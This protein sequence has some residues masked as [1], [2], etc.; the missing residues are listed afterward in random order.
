MASLLP[1][2]EHPVERVLRAALGL[3][4]L[5][6]A[7]VGPKTPWGYLGIV[8]LATGLLGSCPLYTLFGW[9]T[10]PAKAR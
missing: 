3:G 9:S 4:V 8:P 6:L 5:S 10:C 7:F 2:N 1:T